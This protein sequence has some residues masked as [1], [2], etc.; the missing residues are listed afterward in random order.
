MHNVW[1]S[2]VPYLK[3]QI[4]KYSKVPYLINYLLKMNLYS[5]TLN[6]LVFIRIVY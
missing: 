1:K 6:V 4:T 3:L 2:Y 5:T